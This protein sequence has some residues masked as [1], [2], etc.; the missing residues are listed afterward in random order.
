MNIW[1][2]TA[3]CAAGALIGFV[4]GATEQPAAGHVTTGVTAFFAGLLAASLKSDSPINS[5]TMAKL[6]CLYL[7]CVLITYIIGN[8]MRRHRWTDWFLG[9]PVEKI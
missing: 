6:F 7:G 1:I 2:I 4:S 8:L 5:T 9:D 3:T